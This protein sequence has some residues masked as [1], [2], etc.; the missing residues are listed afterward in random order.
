MDMVTEEESRLRRLAK[1][2]K[3]GAL[4]SHRAHLLSDLDGFCVHP[5]YGMSILDVEKV[6]AELESYD[7]DGSGTI[8]KGEFYCFIRNIFGAKDKYDIPEKILEEFWKMLNAG[9]S[10]E[11]TLEQ[12]LAFFWKYF[13]TRGLDT[14]GA[15]ISILDCIGR[16]PT[17][18]EERIVE[19][20]FGN[21]LQTLARGLEVEDSGNAGDKECVEPEPASKKLIRAV[22]LRILGK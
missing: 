21:L 19:I 11:V 12:F 13:W 3:E 5:K 16:V 15:Q 22:L 8:D 20:A 14:P 1:V 6:K 9:D 4:S 7:V 17:W 10:G 18:S 2:S